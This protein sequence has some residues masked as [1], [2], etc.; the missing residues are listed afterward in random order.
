MD[1]K[2]TTSGTAEQ[3]RLGGLLPI[4]F[5]ATNGFI[6]VGKILKIISTWSAERGA[7]IETVKDKFKK[8]YIEAL[9][10]LVHFIH[11][12]FN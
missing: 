9:D 10:F 5:L 6:F 1:F 4:I 2:L 3:G 7:E 12:R 11:L 8:I